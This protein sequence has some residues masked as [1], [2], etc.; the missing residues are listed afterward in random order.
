MGSALLF[1]GVEIT[2]KNANQW[3]AES[4][5]QVQRGRFGR[6]FTTSI[7]SRDLRIGPTDHRMPAEVS[8]PRPERPN[9]VRWQFFHLMRI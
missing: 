6:H 3:V 4:L 9:R 8:F 5:E 1:V 7:G 2:G